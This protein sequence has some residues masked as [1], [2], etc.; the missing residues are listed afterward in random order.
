ML[1]LRYEAGADQELSRTVG[2]SSEA[3]MPTTKLIG[4][5]L[6]SLLYI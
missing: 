5:Q 6:G 2:I 4:V 3:F 1:L